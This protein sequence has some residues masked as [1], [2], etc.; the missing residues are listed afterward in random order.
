MENRTK[1]KRLGRRKEEVNVVQK[2]RIEYRRKKTDF[3]R[4]VRS[5]E[6]QDGFQENRTE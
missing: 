1:Y 3:R 4:T 6:E 5:R 2:N